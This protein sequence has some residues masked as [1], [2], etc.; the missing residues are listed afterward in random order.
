MVNFYRKLNRKKKLPLPRWEETPITQKLEARFKQTQA[1]KRHKGFFGTYRLG[2]DVMKH[3]I[4]K[5]L[6]K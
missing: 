5:A 3:F 4:K 6:W 2:Y 1:Q